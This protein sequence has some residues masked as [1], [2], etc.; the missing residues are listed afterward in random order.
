[1]VVSD[2]FCFTTGITRGACIDDD[3][4]SYVDETTLVTPVAT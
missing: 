4:D 3:G 2:E 1:M